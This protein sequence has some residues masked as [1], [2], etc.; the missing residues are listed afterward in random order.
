MAD[1]A[2]LDVVRIKAL[3]AGVKKAVRTRNGKAYDNTTL[4]ATLAALALA[5]GI[6]LMFVA[7]RRGAHE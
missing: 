3:A 1:L 7:R 2:E 5:S 6:T 4:A